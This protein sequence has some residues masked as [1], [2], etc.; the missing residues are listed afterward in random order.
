[1]D[2]IGTELHVQELTA[3]EAHLAFAKDDLDTAKERCRRL[4]GEELLLASYDQARFDVLRCQNLIR[5]G[6]S[7]KGGEGLKALAR[8]AQET[9]NLDLAARA[10]RLITETLGAL[11]TAP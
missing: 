3:L 6:E 5:D 2:L 9:P 8:H 7:T 1:M 10:W 4:D 11:D